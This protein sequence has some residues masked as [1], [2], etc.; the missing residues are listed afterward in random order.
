MDSDSR[1]EYPEGKVAGI[2]N[3]SDVDAAVAAL[4]QA[5]FAADRIDAITAADVENIETPFDKR[6]LPRLIELF[7]LSL[8]DHVRELERLR[9]ALEA[10]QAVVAVSVDD[11]AAKLLAAGVL[12][13]NGS[14][15]VKYFG[16]WTIETLAGPR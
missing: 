7:L 5:G 4:R 15:R 13:D 11:N 9:Q 12:A 16:K 8:G 10:G 1:L 3:A 14:E 6:G 2:V